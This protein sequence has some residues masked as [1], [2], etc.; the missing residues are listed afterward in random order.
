MLKKHSGKKTSSKKKLS[1]FLSSFLSTTNT[2]QGTSEPYSVEEE[3]E[4]VDGSR[5]PSLDRWP[6]LRSLLVRA[7][8]MEELP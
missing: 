7:H 8:S 4:E 6:G 2:T 3:K 1:T 5:G